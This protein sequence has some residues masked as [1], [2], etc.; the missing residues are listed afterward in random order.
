MRWLA[1]ILAVVLAAAPSVASSAAATTS[2]AR[3]HVRVS[4][5]GKGFVLAESHRPFIPWGYNYDR[6]HEGGLLESYWHEKWPKVVADF[7]QMKAMRGNVVRIHLQFASFMDAPDKPNARNFAQLER[8]VSLAEE[9]GLYLDLTGL[10]C[11]RKQ[12]VPAWYDALDESH[13]WDAQARFWEEVA[14]RCNG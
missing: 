5:D 3:Q 8:L 14:R 10:A 13:R 12:D 7:G 9:T 2:A 11:Y 4:P 1:T 6:N